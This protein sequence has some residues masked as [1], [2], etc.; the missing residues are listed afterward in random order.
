MPGDLE[1]RG[2]EGCH[3]SFVPEEFHIV[4]LVKLSSKFCIASFLQ[5]ACI[6][7]GSSLTSPEAKVLETLAR[8][9]FLQQSHFNMVT[10]HEER[11]TLGENHKDA[12][13]LCLE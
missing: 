10:G 7:C 8:I 13:I 9:I 3:T 5:Y 2:K 12:F 6:C 1:G 4:F 11:R